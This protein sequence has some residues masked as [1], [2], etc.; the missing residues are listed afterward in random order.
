[1]ILLHKELFASICIVIPIFIVTFCTFL[2]Y[3]VNAKREP[4]DPQKKDFSPYAIF[5]V[6]VAVPFVV[7]LDI[8]LLILYSLFFG[9][10]LLLFPVAL[11]LF[12]KPFLIQWILK[13]AQKIGDP[14]LDINS[15]LL[16]AVGLYMPS[17]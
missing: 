7:F 17:I 6:P 14:I 10:M 1:M 4:N 11:L 13:L 2:A 8:L 5:L 12:R 15:Q 9:V 3:R 16:K